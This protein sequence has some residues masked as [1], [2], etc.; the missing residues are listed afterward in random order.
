MYSHVGKAQVLP[1]WSAVGVRVISSE[2]LHRIEP[3]LYTYLVE[4]GLL[5]PLISI[6]TA[7]YTV[8]WSY[9]YAMQLC[10]VHSGMPSVQAHPA[11]QLT[12]VQLGR[13]A[14]SHVQS[15]GL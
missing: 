10:R 11:L 14:L 15:E 5:E 7:T 9:N 13:S 2:D 12:S 8:D 4:D 1:F 3:V 6:S